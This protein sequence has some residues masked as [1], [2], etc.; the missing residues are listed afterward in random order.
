M[1]K[2]SKLGDRAM[3]RQ[4]SKNLSA[5]EKLRRILS[6]QK[7][8]SLQKNGDHKAISHVILAYYFNTMIK[9]CSLITRRLFDTITLVSTNGVSHYPL[10]YKFWKAWNHL[11]HFS[12]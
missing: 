7:V 6:L 8:L 1:K 2:I 9:T 12:L 5:F 4:V 11:A 10:E 3:H